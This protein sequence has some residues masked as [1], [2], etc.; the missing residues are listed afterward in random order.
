MQ[1]ESLQTDE[2][3][4]TTLNNRDLAVTN[5]TQLAVAGVFAGSL[6]GAEVV[7]ADSVFE[8]GSPV[9]TVDALLRL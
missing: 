3:I 8:A 1:S 9:E 6:F 2:R 5:W 4:G 7:G